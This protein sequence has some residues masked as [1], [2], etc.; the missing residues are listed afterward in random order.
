MLHGLVVLPVLF[1]SPTLVSSSLCYVCENDFTLNYTVTAATVPSF[2]QCQLNNAAICWITVMWNRNTNTSS[3][4][5]DS[6]DI[7]ST[8]DTVDKIITAIAE[9]K[10]ASRHQ[11]PQVSYMLSFVCLTDK[12]NDELTL[13]RILHS[14][15]ISENFAEKLTSLLQ[16]V[17][18]F[19]PQSAACYERMDSTEDC[20]RTDP[21]TCQRCQISV[22]KQSSSSQRICASCL[23]HSDDTNL[24]SR[25]VMF[26]LNT[27][28]QM[29]N[30]A[31]I[32]CQLKTCN[33]LKNIER[34]YTE[35][36]IQ[37]DLEAFFSTSSDDSI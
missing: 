11:I 17:S 30:M 7:P 28:T 22:D 35:S 6:I 36:K 5:V 8:D 31:K 37:F 12:C 14:L 9:M 23:H 19:I 32:S 16:I 4:L 2:S 25:Q 3:I 26:S 10:I 1:A 27:R 29:H 20:P 24:L 18:P 21:S 15:V 33:S 34:V 13:K